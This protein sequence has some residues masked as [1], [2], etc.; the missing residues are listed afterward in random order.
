MEAPGWAETS[1]G[2][3]AAGW[4]ETSDGKEVAGWTETSDGKGVAGWTETSDGKEAA[5]WRETS[6][7]KEAT[8]RGVSGRASATGLGGLGAQALKAEVEP[9]LVAC[10]APSG[11]PQHALPCPA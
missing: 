8:G 3:E 1:V 5:G 2:M 9:V 10:L 6:V 11:A 4:A 7:S